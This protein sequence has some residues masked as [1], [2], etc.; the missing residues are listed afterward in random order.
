MTNVCGNARIQRKIIL[1]ISKQHVYV[2][3]LVKQKILERAN[4]KRCFFGTFSTEECEC[5]TI[6]ILL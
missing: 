4:R 2:V 1:T 5:D 3:C 6:K